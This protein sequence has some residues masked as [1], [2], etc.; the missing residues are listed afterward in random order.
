MTMD[1]SARETGM[2]GAKV[3]FVDDEPMVLDGYGNSLRRMKLEVHVAHGGADGLA[4]VAADGPFAVVATDLRMPGMNGLDF[5]AQVR[6]R[7]PDT[8]LILLTGHADLETAMEAINA[9]RLFRF[10]TK[11]CASDRLRS[12]IEAGIRQFELETAERRLTAEL[13][14]E[15]ERRAKVEEELLRV[16]AALEELARVDALT[17]LFNRRCLL[18]RLEAE[19]SRIKRYGGPLSVLM[20]DVD[21]FKAVNDTYGHPVGDRVLAGVAH[22]LAASL[23]R[24]DVAGRVGGE[25]F[26]V[27]LPGTP[28]AGAAQV[29]ER[30]RMTISRR[31]FEVDSTSLHVTCSIGAAGLEGG[32]SSP[33]DVLGRA[34]KALYEAKH[35]GRNRVVVDGA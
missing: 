22:D 13:L 5:L 30:L 35:G 31:T 24:T 28:L 19:L 27:L 1:G 12:A 26:C 9:G 10:L 34:D 15:V 11:P 21:H 23:R 32:G 2:R 4:T 29:A 6:E 7:A 14:R 17:G 16:N 20:I 18:E 25:E 3:L 8:A 33:E